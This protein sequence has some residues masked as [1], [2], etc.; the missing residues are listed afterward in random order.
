MRRVS[1]SKVQC[2]S[3]HDRSGHSH[4][5]DIADPAV[6]QAVLHPGDRLH[7]P[8]RTGRACRHPRDAEAVHAVAKLG[9]LFNS[10]TVEGPEAVDLVAREGIGNE[11]GRSVVQK[12]QVIALEIKLRSVHGRPPFRPIE[13]TVNA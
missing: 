11:G 5:K 8:R 12:V 10:G 7:Q 1:L 2:G 3:Q 9:T 13:I 4:W 6:R